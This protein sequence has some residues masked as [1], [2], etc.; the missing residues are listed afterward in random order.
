V[1]FG[2]Y[3]SPSFLSL[4][5]IPFI[6]G[7]VGGGES[8]PR[9]FWYSL[10][11]KGMMAEMLRE[12][13]RFLLETDPSVRLTVKRTCM[14]LAKTEET[15]VHLKRLGSNRVKVFGESAI[16]TEELSQLS[17]LSQ[18]LKKEH[19]TEQI[20]FISI[21]RFLHWKGFSLGLRAFAMAL[22]GSGQQGLKNAE[23]W[24]VGDGPEFRRLQD[25]VNKLG[26]AS[27]VK[28]WGRLS[29]EETMKKL[30]ACHVLVHPSL[31]DSGGWVCLEA[32]AAGKPVVC[33]DLGGPATQV[34]HETGFKIFPGN[35]AQVIREIGAAMVQLANDSTLRKHQKESARE[36]IASEYLWDRKRE[37]FGLLYKEVLQK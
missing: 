31:H 36:L 5:P 15:R 28:F 4:L 12:T 19:A 27:S 24:L 10:G 22:Q 34:T 35:P 14:T 9:A 23:Y 13:A 33:L 30:V 21:G 6:W 7:P 37:F 25:L 3:W 8:A 11:I 16:S 1:T 18:N 32:M 26:I 20:T 29:R 2:K 17:Q